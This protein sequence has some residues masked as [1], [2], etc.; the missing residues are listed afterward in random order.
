M[1]FRV[2]RGPRGGVSQLAKS[3]AD[4]SRSKVSASN[5][6]VK[7]AKPIP[8]W[9]I[10]K[11]ANDASSF[12]QLFGWRYL[13][14]DSKKLLWIDLIS[15]KKRLYFGSQI[16]GGDADSLR[17]A[18]I[19]LNQSEHAVGDSI[20]NIRVLYTD[21]GRQWGLWAS[22]VD[23]KKPSYFCDINSVD[24]LRPIHVLDLSTESP[25]NPEIERTPSRLSA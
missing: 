18:L 9:R 12:A 8:L 14:V 15:D 23:A 21:T 19:A 6:S 22:S 2:E 4:Q 11:P 24:R 7:I 20:Y 25:N 5:H 13:I 16:V 1:T 3:L 10:I 17:L